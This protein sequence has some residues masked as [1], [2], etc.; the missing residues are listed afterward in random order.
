MTDPRIVDYVFGDPG[1]ATQAELLA[2]AYVMNSGKHIADYDDAVLDALGQRITD[3]G[4][5][6]EDEWAWIKSHRHALI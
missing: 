4:A 2:E 5:I 3:E 1:G 6:N